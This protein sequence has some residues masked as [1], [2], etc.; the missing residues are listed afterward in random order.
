MVLNHTRGED[1]EAYLREWALWAVRNMTEVS[2][3]ARQKIIELQPQAVEESEELLAKGL[4]VELNRETGRPRVVKR[5]AAPSVTNV[6]LIDDVEPA[7]PSN[8][9]ITEL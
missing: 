3:A 4:D 5:D 1:G 7:I 6:A 8:W 2:D 9:K